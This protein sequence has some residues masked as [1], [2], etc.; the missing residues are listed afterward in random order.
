MNKI[1]LLSGVFAGAFLF[2]TAALAQ[3]AAAPTAS[4][5][6]AESGFGDIIVTAQRRDER[7]QDVPLAVTAVESKALNAAGALQTTDLKLVA[8]SLDVP[9]NNGY[10]T[11]YLRG[12]GS[13]AI[14]PGIES[15]IALYVDGVYVGNGTSVLS[16]SSIE[17]VEVLKGPQGTLF[18]R[19][20][21]GGLI[22]VVTRDPKT[23]LG[24]N[25][26]V[27]YGNYDTWQTT[28][29]LTGGLAEGVSADIA[30]YGTWQGKGYGTN[31]FNGQEVGKLHHDYGFR[32]K[33]LIEPADNVQIRVTGDYS[34]TSSNRNV[35]R[36]PLGQTPPPAFGAAYGG[37]PW[38]TQVDMQPYFKNKQGGVAVRADVTLGDITLVS[39]T[40]YRKAKFQMRTDFD[41]TASTRSRSLEQTQKDHQFSQELQL[42]SGNDSALNWTLGLFYWNAKGEFD[43]FTITTLNLPGPSRLSGNADQTSESIAP[44]AQATYEFL[45]NTNLT[46]GLRYTYE[47]REVGGLVTA[48]TPG[49]PRSSGPPLHSVDASKATWRIALDHKFSDDLMV[50]A[51]QNRGFKSGGFSVTEFNA[52]PYLP[53]VLDASEVGFKAMLLD[54]KLRFNGAAF[55]YNYKNVQVYSTAGTGLVITNGGKGEI[56]GFELEMGARITPQFTLNAGYTYL[57]SEWK[58]FPNAPINLPNPAGGKTQTSGSAA[59]NDM[60]M[61]PHH[62]VS[63]SGSYALP[64]GDNSLTLNA[65]YYYNSGYFG[66]PDNVARQKGYSLVNASLRYALPDDR[67]YISVWGRNLTDEAVN[68]LPLHTS[69]NSPGFTVERANYAPPRTYGV[70]V[71]TK[72]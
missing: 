60:P 5:D 65:N 64:I 36:I 49:G 51:S 1:R 28:A 17:R 21:T 41:V 62:V 14:G 54:R 19:N 53:E 29:Y 26:S 4:A 70:T 46:L 72:F 7:L 69:Q 30:G 13:R 32:S 9:V 27:S 40:A 20:S 16:F 35:Q 18:G 52:A 59:G 44:Y 56:K 11:P 33:W 43:P 67:L 55:Y 47:K 48:I 39:T 57:D 68:T 23:D 15:P 38:D 58:R 6:A 31:L 2:G 8:T 10:V 63:V 50:Y 45:P 71:G 24:G 61:A 25:A 22:Q 66:E 3:N 37:S 34:D 12:V 42:L